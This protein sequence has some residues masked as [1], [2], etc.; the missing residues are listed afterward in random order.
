MTFDRLLAQPFL[1]DINQPYAEAMHY[2]QADQLTKRLLWLH[3]AALFALVF[4]NGYLRLPF[5]TPSPLGWRIISPQEGIIL[6]LIGIMAVMAPVVS[7]QRLSNHYLWRLL[8]ALCLIIFSYLFIYVSGGAI[9]MRYHLYLIITYMII[10][11][12]WR[13]SWYMVGLA[14]LQHAFFDTLKPGWLYFYGSNT[15][16][17]LLNIFF[18][19]IA[20]LFATII[21]RNYRAAVEALV[22][23]KQ[24]NEQFLAI[25]SHELK[26]PL[27]SMRGYVEVLQRKMKRASDPSLAYVQKMDDQ[28]ARVINMVRDLLDISTRQ[29][30]HV[31]LDIETL[32]VETLVNQAIEEVQA[33]AHRHTIEVQ[34]NLRVLLEGDRT[35]L[36][37]VLINL[38]NN[39]I[40]YSPQSDKI[41][42]KV[43]SARDRVV[44]SV[45]D[46]G[47]GLSQSEKIKIFEPYFRGSGAKRK[48]VPGGLGMGLYVSE[49]I[50]RMHKGRLWVESTLGRGSTFSFMIPLRHNLTPHRVNLNVSGQGARL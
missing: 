28:L 30:G 6:L 20:G 16:A 38:L 15:L 36:G 3:Y 4:L 26:T 12:D 21:S 27:T 31:E 24:R 44:I 41:I 33:L 34:G 40:K 13:L 17:P 7:H 46:S 23:A 47:I 22:L 11:A 18:L 39:A 19:V 45:Q 42:V 8:V 50:I 5:A 14:I 37:Q 49:E 29:S 1:Q 2:N 32:S 43:A 48:D 9:E 10:Y 25:A 35:R